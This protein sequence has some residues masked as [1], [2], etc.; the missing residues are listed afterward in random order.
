MTKAATAKRTT[1]KTGNC[2]RCRA[3][4]T[5]PRSITRGYGDRC[6]R[7]KRREDAAHAAG[8]KTT[9]VDKARQ[10]IADK[11]IVPVR[12]RRVFQVVS[13]NGTDR[14]LTAANTCNCPAGLRGKHSCYHSAAA[15]MLAA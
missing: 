5:N 3:L 15:A 11:A 6:W 10:L 1:T 14:Y 7:E 13:S 4:L 8:F 2:R 12:G 9:T